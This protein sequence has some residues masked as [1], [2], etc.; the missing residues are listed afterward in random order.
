MLRLLPIV[1][2]GRNALPNLKLTADRSSARLMILLNDFAAEMVVLNVAPCDLNNMYGVKQVTSVSSFLKP[3]LRLPT[4][5]FRT[6][7]YLQNNA[8]TTV[9]QTVMNPPSPTYH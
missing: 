8:T 2:L 5:L 1:T 6:L 7:S 4:E 3:I 9:H